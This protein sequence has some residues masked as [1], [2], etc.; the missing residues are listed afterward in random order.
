MSTGVVPGRKRSMGPC[1]TGVIPASKPR[2]MKTKPRFMAMTPVLRRSYAGQKGVNE[3][4]YVVIYVVTVYEV[5][6]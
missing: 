6:S 4:I 5:K 1:R 3:K 2:Y